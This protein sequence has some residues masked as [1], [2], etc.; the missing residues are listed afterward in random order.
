MSDR[1]SPEREPVDP[2]VWQA[3]DRLISEQ[4]MQAALDQVAPIL[5]T[6]RERDD[7]DAWTR[8]LITSVQLQ[9]ALHGYETAVRFLRTESWPQGT[10]NEHRRARVVLDLFYAHSLV[11]YRN[12]YRYQIVQRETVVS[13]ETV[14]LAAWTMDQLVVEINRAFSRAWSDRATWGE[15]SLGALS[16]YVEQNDYPARI[17]G[18]LR[19]TV[20]YLW[21]EVLTDSSAWSPAQTNGI[22]RLDLP[23]LVRGELETEATLD[24]PRAHPLEKLAVVLGDLE[25]FHRQ[26]DRPEA[27]FEA[28]RQRIVFLQQHTNRRADL[29]TLEQGLRDRLE[30]LGR[31]FPWWSKGMATLAE[32]VR[33]FDSAP[34]RLARAHRVATQGAEAFPESIGGV[35][36]RAIATQIEQPSFQLTGMAVDGLGRSSIGIDH[37]N[38]KALHFRAFRL[39]L[40]QV[41]QGTGGPWRLVEPRRVTAMLDSRKADIAWST[42]LPTTGDFSTHRTDVIPPIEAHGFYLVVGSARSDFRPGNNQIQGMV[43][44]QT[45]LVLLSRRTADDRLEVTVRQG[46]SGAAIDGATITVLRWQSGKPPVEAAKHATGADGRVTFAVPPR[47]AWTLLTRHEDQAVLDRSAFHGRRSH[48]PQRQEPRTFLYTDR[49]IY[50]PGQEILWKTVTYGPAREAGDESVAT[51]GEPTRSF[52]VRSGETVSIVLRDANGEVVAESETTSNDFGTATGSFRIPEGRLLGAWSLQATWNGHAQVRVEAYKRPTFEVAI[53]DPEGALRLNRE[54]TLRGSATYYFGLPV[55]EGE[56]DWRVV[57]EPDFRPYGRYGF[58]R[59]W[60]QPGAPEVVAA[61]RTRIDPDGTFT[62]T[63]EPAGDE[64]DA[65]AISGTRAGGMRRQ[66][67]SRYN[68]RIEADVTSAGGETRSAQRSFPV[69]TVAVEANI[70]H[71]SGFVMA[72]TEISLDVVRRALDGRPLAGAGQW[73]LVRVDQPERALLPVEQPL[74]PAPD[75]V[76]AF[77]TDS[78]RRRPRWRPGYEPWQI[79]AAWPDGPEVATGPAHHGDDG[80]AK[81]D[82]G[83]LEPGL[84]R[85]HYQTDDAFGATFDTQTELWVVA[86]DTETP[87]DSRSPSTVALPAVLALSDEQAQPGE[88]VRVLVAS[89]IPGQPMV[90]EAL[91]GNRTVMRREISG[92]SDTWVDL[93]IGPDDRGGLTLRLTSVADYQLIELQQR[94]D[95]PWEDRKLDITFT[96]FRDKLR[97][98]APET[99]RIALRGEEGPL[100]AGAAEILASMYDRSLDLF[101]PHQ[102]PSLLGIYPIRPAP[103]ALATVLGQANVI[104]T[105]GRGFGHRAH[106]RYLRADRLRFFDNYPIGGPGRFGGGHVPVMRM[107]AKAMPEGATFEADVA[108]APMAMSANAADASAVTAPP[109]PAPPASPPTQDGAAG[110]PGGISGALRENFAETAFWLPQLLVDD[111]GGVSF[112]FTAPDSVTAWNVWIEA[113]TRDLRSGSARREV[114][115]TRDLLVR[116][117]VPRFLREGDRARVVILVDNAG[118]SPLEGHLELDI[119][120]P[121]TETSRAEAF[122]LEKGGL[123]NVPFA[124]EPGQSVTVEVA[125]HAPRQVGDAALRVL[126]QAKAVGPSADHGNDHGD[127]LADGELRPLPVLPGRMHL[128]TSRFAAV[129]PAGNRTLTFGDLADAD[130]QRSDE[131]LVVQVDGQLLLSVLEAMPYLVDYPYPSVEAMLERY[132]SAGTLASLFDRVPA[133]AEVAAAMAAERDSRNERFDEPDAN[134][135]IDLVETPWLRTARG[136]KGSSWGLLRILDPTVAANTRDAALDELTRAQ[137]S[138]GAFPWFPGGPPSPTITLQVLFGLAKALDLEVDTVPENVVQRAW[139]YLANHWR[140]E[141]RPRIRRDECCWETASFLAYVLSAYPDTERW[142]GGVLTDDDRAQMLDLGMRHWKETSPLVKVY[143]ATALARA[144]RQ[145][146]ADLVLD[147]VLDSA[148]TDPDLGTYWQPEPRAWLFYNDTLVGHTATLRAL[149]ELRPDDPHR[150]GLIQWLLLH[151]QLNHWQSTRGTAEVLY[152]LVRSM[153]RDAPLDAPDAANVTIGDRQARF[154]FTPA[155]Y[156]EG[157]NQIVIRGDEVDPKTMRSISVENE[158]TRAIFARATWHY[159]TD[160]PPA[161]GDGDLFRIERSVFRRTSTRDGYE[162]EPLGPNAQVEVGDQLEIQ[163]EIHSRAPAEYVH[164]RDPRPAGLEPEAPRSGYRWGDG[165][166]RYEQIGESGTDLFFERLPAGTATVRY[167]LRANLAGHFQ[168][169]PAVIQ[170]VYAPAFAG[171]SAG[172]TLAIEPRGE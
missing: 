26:G 141:M 82:L 113:L 2:A 108:D 123:R 76:D 105:G 103:S 118:A 8:A 46:A 102:P 117:Q 40:E 41:L 68:F 61:G 42:E 89:G 43:L 125:L 94:L 98:G 70:E 100:E 81:L 3:I 138:D 21:A 71:T 13:T 53:D 52:D 172:S 4:K 57:R 144:D 79:A 152:T 120:D 155:S 165:L 22:F 36:C 157:N 121:A 140:Q 83:A 112:T 14:D 95:V 58:S 166:G 156:L 111:D 34:D 15:A 59:W 84:L 17:R 28:A 159:A 171:H 31:R 137:R 48:R 168:A 130:P 80:I 20:S 93:P 143:L 67:D 124:V 149:D 148:R 72:G 162:L 92:G 11:Q 24:D 69:G 154:T 139:S 54:A 23:A 169:A 146:D 160:Q 119:I 91:R 85:L 45:E 37:A 114:Q 66:P 126:G 39:P 153:R 122:G 74:P 44:Q 62:V 33:D 129:P 96:T 65:P 38:L 73:R 6:A 163:L 47:Q 35:Q 25:A 49:S 99:W 158:G 131:Q 50:R 109:S 75:A 5:S 29:E 88:T 64:R 101:A 9:T 30:T 18:T 115:T 132:V 110:A 16:A 134:R 127:V 63:F 97:P 32:M 167:R 10:E 107:R 90:L 56:V 151:K 136:G 147:S 161:A 19:D 12:A 7:V 86:Q 1:S 60:P 104:Y 77:L 55:S 27:A 128:V 142:T 78:D 164:V 150:D 106:A 116:P 51:H 145:Q 170:S 135:T 133:L 87:G